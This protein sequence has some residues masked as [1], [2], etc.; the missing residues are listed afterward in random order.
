MIALSIPPHG[1]T[2]IV[3]SLCRIVAELAEESL[4]GWISVACGTPLTMRVPHAHH[5]LLSS[6]CLASCLSLRWNNQSMIDGRK[7]ASLEAWWS[8]GLVA[9]EHAPITMETKS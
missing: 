1:L 2:S 3:G 9:G 6:S 4:C 5:V 7:M 8:G